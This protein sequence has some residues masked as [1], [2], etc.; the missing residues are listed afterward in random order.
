MDSDPGPSRRGTSW[1]EPASLDHDPFTH[2]AVFYRDEP[3]YLAHTVPFI[4]DG[5]AAGEPVA[6]AVP[7]PNLRAIQDEVGI[8]GGR[9][10]EVRWLDMTKAGRNPGRII[11]GVLRA[12]ADQHTDR[13]ARII[14]EPIWPGRSS[15]EYPACVQ[16]E[17]LINAAFLGREVTI[18]C[19]YDAQ[20]LDPV[21]LADAAATHPIMV[22]G[23]RW[24]RSRDYAPEQVVDA[25]NTPLTEPASAQEHAVAADQLPLIRRW[26]RQRAAQAGVETD[27]L[28]DVT[29]VVNELVTNSIEHGT[30]N[31]RV[32][33]WTTK[34]AVVF[35][36]TNAGTIPD[37]LVGRLPATPGQI[38]GRGLLATN[39]LTDLVR[40]H[41][42][43]DRTTIRVHFHRAGHPR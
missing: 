3:E 1:Y 35:Q 18:L 32:L 6:V 38:R 29:F 42:S 15:S 16:H 20:G 21:V 7:G 39:L 34:D 43:D 36:T 28:D 4:L 14:G 41:R 12:F 13:R 26:A 37:P 24:W 23:D 27:R 40:I 8:R 2:S 11:P 33:A 17:A 19:P 9:V 5:Q 31:P 22:D 25:Y 10:D 30:G